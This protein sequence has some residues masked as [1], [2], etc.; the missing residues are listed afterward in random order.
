MDQARFAGKCSRCGKAI[1]KG[2][3]V[4]FYPGDRLIICK[5]DNCGGQ[6]SRDFDSACFDENTW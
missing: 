6:A 3:D 5:D 4:F 1:A 2:A